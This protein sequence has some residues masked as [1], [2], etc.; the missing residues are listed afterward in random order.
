MEK[1]KAADQTPN[2]DKKQALDTAIRQIEK[3][4]GKGAVM[5]LG[6]RP[7]LQVDAIPTGSLALDAALGI[8]GVP[9]GRIIEI[10]GPESS[11][12]TTLALHIVA[13]AQKRGGEVAFVDAEH[14]LDPD[15]AARIGV[16]I[17]S[18]LVSQPDTG[19]Q[20]LEIT[21]TFVG[22]QA[23]LMSQALRKLAGN[24]S[25]T[26]CVVIFINQLRMKIGVMY[27][28]PETTTGGNALKFYASVRIDIR[29]TEAIKNGSEVIGNR[30]RAKIVKNKCAPPFK[31]AFFDIMYGE[32]ISKWGEMVDL[33]VQ[34]ELINKS[35]SWFSIG[36][37]RIGQGRD[38]A[39]QYLIDHPDVADRIEQSIRDNMWK[40][41][42]KNAKP[43]ASVAAKPVS[44]SADDF[45]DD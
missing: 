38:S 27:G 36:D 12:K 8:G 3:N 2:N 15:Y 24:I 16:D 11:G 19:E 7:D 44:I 5:R 30:T 21:D 23:R 41:Q 26:N 28:N 25:K 40:L 37:E 4:F 18:M 14:A 10:Y 17:D 29:R 32:G 20:A 13:Q 43:P 45:N 42:G 34:L 9:K 31:E 39:K 6:D 33:A 22:L 35:G 1:K